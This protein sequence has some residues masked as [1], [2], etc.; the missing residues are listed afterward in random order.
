MSRQLGIVCGRVVNWF[1]VLH[2]QGIDLTTN[3]HIKVEH[4]AREFA[5]DPSL[6]EAADVF[7]A[8]LGALHQRGWTPG[9]L[10][11]AVYNKMNVNEN[12]KWEQKP[13]GTYQH[14]TSISPDQKG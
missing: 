5:D 2:D 1:H 3:A 4:E 14:I 6:E 9:D 7:I 12:R 8:L 13:D 10:A 11:A